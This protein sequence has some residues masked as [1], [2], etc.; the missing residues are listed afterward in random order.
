MDNAIIPIFY[1]FYVK[2]CGMVEKKRQVFQL[3][4]LLSQP[5]EAKSMN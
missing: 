4:S 3:A 2:D 1:S 5:S